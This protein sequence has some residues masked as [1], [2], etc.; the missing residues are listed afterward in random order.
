MPATGVAMPL[1]KKFLMLAGVAAAAAV[2]YWWFAGRAAPPDP[3][4][5]L[6]NQMRTRAVIEH[7]RRITVWYKSCPEVPGVNP[8]V[9]VIWPGRLLYTLDLA[10]S[11]LS[12]ANGVLSVSTPPIEVEEPAVPSDLAQ[13]IASNPFW[14]LRTDASIGNAALKQATPVARYLSVY[15][16]RHDPTLKS[17]FTKELETYLRG[18][19]GG[20]NVPVREVLIDIAEAKLSANVLPQLELCSGTAATANGVPF[21]RESE[22]DYI[23]VFPSKSQ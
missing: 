10:H 20:L 5:V 18:V 15:F 22:G 17:Y 1:V 14:N 2:A 21:V 7:E 23:Y 9:F 19:A 8:E 13:F 3:I 12:L 6:V 16:L 11:R 4:M